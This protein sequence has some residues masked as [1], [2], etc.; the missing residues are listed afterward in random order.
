[1]N[2]LKVIEKERAVIERIQDSYTVPLKKLFRYLDQQSLAFNLASIRKYIAEELEQV[3]KVSTYNVSIYAIKKRLHFLR[4]MLKG[5]LSVLEDE[6]LEKLI[7]E[8]KPRLSNYNIAADKIMTMKD[9]I[10]FADLTDKT[11]I[12][13]VAHV[14]ARTG[15]RISECMG[16]LIKNTARIDDHYR[17]SIVGKGK[18]DRLV[19]LSIAMFEE[20][21]DVFGSTE[22]LFQKR[23]G[24]RYRNLTGLC[25]RFKRET[26]K[27]LGVAHPPHD[28]RHSHIQ[29]LVDSGLDHK[30]IS[31]S[32]GHASVRFM[33][34]N[35][36]HR[37]LGF[38]DIQG[39]LP[40]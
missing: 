28:F 1:M 8:I 34:D 3:E 33:L 26:N 39:V 6:N 4:L 5:K 2:D 16:I 15:L 38:Q 29:H 12:K 10:A 36:T 27:I 25:N 22:F 9:M 31:K 30:A 35:Y 40:I 37:S 32:V 21:V 19:Y 17:I 24:E 7:E 14:L 23:N 18:K 13:Y 11:L 20:I